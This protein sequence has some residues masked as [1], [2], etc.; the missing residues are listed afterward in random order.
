MLTF[1]LHD[2]LSDF[3]VGIMDAICDGHIECNDL[4]TSITGTPLT[5]ATRPCSCLYV[6]GVYLCNPSLTGMAHSMSLLMGS[7]GFLF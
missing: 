3:D 5:L 6:C 4:L 2:L 7:L 1:T